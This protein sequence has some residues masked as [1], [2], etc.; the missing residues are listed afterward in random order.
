MKW[1]RAVWK[2]CRVIA[3]LD[4]RGGLHVQDVWPLFIVPEV[5]KVEHK[6]YDL[7]YLLTHCASYQYP[8]RLEW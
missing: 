2:F 5:S 3:I 8:P 1:R 6:S 4:N 7:W